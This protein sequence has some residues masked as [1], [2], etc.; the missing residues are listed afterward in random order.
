MHLVEHHHVRLRR[1][2]DD[3]HQPFGAGVERA[4]DIRL[5]Q[6]DQKSV[7]EDMPQPGRFAGAPGSEEEE[8]L[9]RKGEKAA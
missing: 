6:V 7:G 9:L 5:K 2:G 1:A 8:A 4:M 3:L